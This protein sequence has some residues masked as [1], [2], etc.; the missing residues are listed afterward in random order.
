[1][2]RIHKRFVSGLLLL[3]LCFTGCGG[4]G[5]TSE[6]VVSNS[7]VS[8]I[9]SSSIVID[10]EGSA[11]E[12]SNILSEI[13]E[14]STDVSSIISSA[15]SETDSLDETERSHNLSLDDIPEYDGSPYYVINN[16]EPFF[17]ED[18]LTTTS[19][20]SYSDLDELGRCGVAYANIGQDLMPTEERG[21]IGQVKPSGWH[22][23]KYDC[24]DGKFSYNRCHLIGYQLTAENANICCLITGTRYLN[25]DGMLPFENMV[26]DYIKETNNHVLYRVTPIFEGT[27]LV[28]RGV[29]MEAMSV[30]DKGDGILYNVFCYNVQ[31]GVI[32]D[33]QTG[34]SY[35]SD[36]QS[37][38]SAEDETESASGAENSDND[39]ANAAEEN[40]YIINKSSKKIHRQSCSSLKQMK[41][42]NKKEV[43]STRDELISQGYD[44]CKKCNP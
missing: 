38:T 18:D 1:M 39:T 37:N 30:E 20:E 8:S 9:T 6:N 31:P 17:T 14:E 10:N 27:E 11:V 7:I 13:A 24:V 2:H 25:I 12:S 41:D 28:A 44:P 36:E 23:V 42:S 43:K 16:N 15:V 40:T 34:D 35:L 3:S 4:S 19:F 26:A 33:Y 21:S 5:D 29:Q 22:T 32:I